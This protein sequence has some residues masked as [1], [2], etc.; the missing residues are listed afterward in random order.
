MQ[1]KQYLSNLDEAANRHFAPGGIYHGVAGALRFGRE[2][3][4]GLA[5][6]PDG[7][8]E[9]Q[10][11]YSLLVKRTFGTRTGVPIN[12]KEFFNEVRGGM[13]HAQERSERLHC[14]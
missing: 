14:S 7:E 8:K 2:L 5:G 1:A 13:Q 11:T 4:Y 9:V 10:A 6:S 12:A 3:G